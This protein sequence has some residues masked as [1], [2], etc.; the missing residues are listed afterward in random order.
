M[1]YDDPDKISPDRRPAGA[2]QKINFLSKEDISYFIRKISPKHNFLLSTLLETPAGVLSNELRRKCRVMN[3][4]HLTRKL[5]LA[6][7]MIHCEMEPCQ[8]NDG[9]GGTI[10]RIQLDLESRELAREMLGGRI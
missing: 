5:R 1:N 4:H 6:G 7:L 3:I 2:H 10:R 8:S 9:S